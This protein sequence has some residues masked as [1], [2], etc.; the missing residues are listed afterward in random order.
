MTDAP[1][2]LQ[3]RFYSAPDGLR[4]HMRD[5]GPRDSAALPIV[6]LPGLSRNSADFHA[7]A[8]AIAGGDAGPARRVVALDYRGRGLSERDPDWKKYDL[9]IES[10]DIQSMLAAAGIGEAI[11]IGTSRGGIHCMLLAAFRPTLMRAVVMNDIGPVL[12]PRGLAR[13]RSYVGK[14]PSPSHWDDAVAMYKQLF[15]AHFT[16][17][18]DPEWLAYAQASLEEKDGRLVARY[19]PRLMKILENIDLESPLPD[20]W[21]QFE[22]LRHLPLLVIRGENSDLLTEETLAQMLA[23]HGRAEAF[24]VPGQGHAPLL[25]DRPSMERICAFIAGLADQPA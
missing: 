11:F 10:G 19:D 4:L 16:A 22:G 8:M 5:Y 7:I 12:E 9:T 6:C 1:P 14:L 21:P 17:L 20:L 24:T 2:P 23:R 13:I 3:S 18:D 15:G 25:A